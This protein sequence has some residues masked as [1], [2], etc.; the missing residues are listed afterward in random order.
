LK[1]KNVEKLHRPT[2]ISDIP[3]ILVEKCFK[4]VANSSR[5]VP[6]Y[7][8]AILLKNVSG[9]YFL[10]LLYQYIAWW[11]NINTPPQAF[12]SKMPTG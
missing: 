4:N 3:S 7:P 6:R 5:V 9:V 11:Y 12:L 8:V 10:L 2:D 1:K